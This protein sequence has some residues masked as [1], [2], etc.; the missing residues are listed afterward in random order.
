[1]PDKKLIADLERLRAELDQ[2]AKDNVEARTRLN[3]II[4]DVERRLSA[5]DDE[6]LHR[7]LLD[8]IRETIHRFE[9]EHP[10]ATA[11]LNDIMVTLSNMGI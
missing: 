3:G 5:P 1:M 4:S 10:R 7:N 8:D 9:A 11:I 6:S 2:L